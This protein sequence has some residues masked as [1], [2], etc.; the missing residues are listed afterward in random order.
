VGS[1]GPRAAATGFAWH[2]YGRSCRSGGRTRARASAEPVVA[3]GPA[4]P[5]AG[6]G[7]VLLQSTAFVDVGGACS[8]VVGVLSLCASHTRFGRGGLRR[9]EAY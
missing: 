5:A 1:G 7:A 3:T 9:F 4:L 8:G 6:G 2:V